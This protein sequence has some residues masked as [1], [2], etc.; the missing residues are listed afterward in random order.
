MTTP[1]V[2][3]GKTNLEVKL[4]SPAT[5]TVSVPSSSSI[6][7]LVPGAQGPK[8]DKGTKWYSGAGVPASGL[9][10]VDD[11][12]LNETNG[13]VYRKST[14]TTWVLE[15]NLTGPRGIEG[16]KWL[17]GAGV[18]ASGLGVITDFYLNSTNADYYEKTTATV[19]T[20]RGNIKGATGTMSLGTV[21][22]G[23]AGSSVAITN[24]GTP[25]AGIF[26][27]T[28]PRGDKGAT[29]TLALGTVTTSAAG[30]AAAITNTG[31]PE[32]GVFNFTIPRGDKGATGTMSVGTT[33]TGAPGTNA[34]VTNTGTPEA[35]IFNFTIPRGDKGNTG[36][37]SVG[38]V[39][40]GA[41]G[42]SAT[43][44]NTG[45]PEAGVFNFTIPRGDKGATG[46]LALGTVTTG[47]AG[48]NVSITN[49]GTPEAGVFNFTIPRG[50]KGERGTVWNY[51]TAAPATG[52]GLV[53]DWALNTNNGDVYEKTGAAVWTLRGNIKGA[54][55]T[56]SLG[57]V[58]TGAAGSAAS[59]TNTGTATAGVFN[60]VIPKGDTGERGPVGPAGSTVEATFTPNTAA[61]VP[62]TAKGLAGQTGDLQQWQNSAGT[63]VAEVNADGTFQ[64]DVITPV[65]KT[66]HWYV[67]SNSANEALRGHYQAE[68]NPRWSI[69]S[70]N[71]A[72]GNSGLTLNAPGATAAA[73]G[74]KFGNIGAGIFVLST[75]NG[76]AQ[77]ERMRV[78]AN[79]DTSFQGV[80]YSNQN[81]T[82]M[83]TAAATA[84]V[85][86][87][88]RTLQFASAYWTG[89]A[90]A[91]ETFNI[92]D[93]RQGAAPGTA[94]GHRLVIGTSANPD[95]NLFSI[96]GDGSSNVGIG[97]SFT[98][99]AAQLRISTTAPGKVATV[100]RGAASQT[101]NLLEFR[102]NADALLASV[103]FAGRFAAA[104]GT[105]AL[106]GFRFQSDLDTGL[107]R[108]AADQIGFATTGVNRLTLSGTALTST[109]AFT[110]T[111]L[112]TS[113]FASVGTTAVGG[114]SQLYAVSTAANFVTLGLR[115]A[116]SQ[117]ADL[118]QWQNSAGTVL[119]RIASD[120]SLNVNGASIANN[121]LAVYS[122][123][124]AGIPAIV[125]G[126]ASQTGDLQQ[127][128]NSAGTMLAEVMANGSF[129]TVGNV[130]A[131]GN[132]S[133]FGAGSASPSMTLQGVSGTSTLN[134][135]SNAGSAGD[136]IVNVSASGTAGLS[137]LRFANATTQISTSTN[138]GG[139]MDYAGTSHAF[140]SSITVNGT[141][142]T[143][144][145]Q[146]N[147]QARSSFEI[148]SGSSVNS[149]AVL[150][151]MTSYAW[152]PTITPFVGRAAASQTA[153]LLN[154]QN[155][156]GT[157]LAR[158]DSG[159]NFTANQLNTTGLTTSYI[160]TPTTNQFGLPLQVTATAAAGRGLV[161][162]G[163]NASQ[164]GDLQQWQNSAGAILA[165]VYAS[166]SMNFT[167]SI[168]GNG[169][170]VVET[171]DTFL[172]INQ[173]SQFSNGIWTGSSPIKTG[174]NGHI[175]VG[176]SGG[177]GN[178]ALLATSNGDAV[179]RITLDGTNGIA[180]FTGV[181]RAQGRLRAGFNG[182]VSSITP[183]TTSAAEFEL[184]AQSLITVGEAGAGSAN[185]AITLYRTYGGYRQGTGMRL[186]HK[187]SGG[188][189]AVQYGG[190][191]NNSTDSPSY[192]TETYA[193]LLVVNPTTG[194][195]T[196]GLLSEQ[197]NRVFSLGNK[198]P[199]AGISATGT[200][201][202]TTFLRGDGTWSVPVGGVTSVNTRTGAVTGLA[203]ANAVVDL[204]TNQSIAGQK[205]FSAITT[206]SQGFTTGV[207]NISSG[208]HTVSGAGV[209]SALYAAAALTLRPDASLSG[210]S[211]NT[212]IN[213]EGTYWNGTASATT[214]G[215][216]TYTSD[217]T[218]PYFNFTRDIYEKGSRVFSP[219]NLVPIS[220]ISATGTASSTTYLRGDGTWATVVGGVT[221]VNSRTG[222]V[223]GLAEAAN[224][225]D[226]TNTQSISGY[227]AFN[228]AL[229]VSGPAGST[230]LAVKGA[231][232]Q[233]AALAEWSD[234]G[235][236]SLVRVENDGSFSVF[237]TKV[238]RTSL[239]TINA[240]EKA[241]VVRGFASQSANLQEWWGVSASQVWGSV[242]GDGGL[243]MR[244]GAFGTISGVTGPGAAVVPLF[245]RGAASQTA[246]LTEWQNSAGTVMTQLRPTGAIYS[247]NSDAYAG[248]HTIQTVPTSRGLAIRGAAG[249]TMNLAEFQDS[250]GTV[251]TYLSANGTIVPQSPMSTGSVGLRIG[252][253]IGAS[254]NAGT[255][256]F[257]DGSGWKLNF[258]RANDGVTVASI[259]DRGNIVS[260][261]TNDLANLMIMTAGI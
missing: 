54:T 150:G 180:T 216:I 217:A 52:L 74:V 146:V 203:E 140:N 230:T 247:T 184:T 19:W 195:N 163:F 48:S 209:S 179:R 108:P 132:D 207:A 119:S 87:N 218:N 60:F 204:T 237:S 117:T 63:I 170:V 70:D 243:T 86:A 147:S 81:L 76:T 215:A 258:A 16:S 193:D 251:L 43:I 50:D 224:V 133:R 7:V 80:V 62:L 105:V 116:A 24:T 167:G 10:L 103:G 186:T 65:I 96:A 46:T 28:I 138:G 178:V 115:G 90:S 67:L 259:D 13:D 169:K 78:S 200:P 123:A 109:V 253:G 38:T 148:V 21:T 257:G 145:L 166:G 82:M 102:S 107:Y 223:T 37:M 114:V 42:S 59:I 182:L 93:A 85:Q 22:T 197:G 211:R 124:A 157:A 32:A 34:T 97:E 227:K 99:S 162:Q 4:V 39:T 101:A 134:V 254:P 72:S 136:A 31:T 5:A 241:L 1:I 249:Q 57:T 125:R 183:L 61:G 106:P 208:S 113:G 187:A 29:G 91:V 164:A 181:T 245:V 248:I 120:G 151:S 14:A 261:T 235:S 192:G 141:T 256:G 95:A 153:D 246:N 6:E 27:F 165:A 128:Q 23:A 35:G 185:P 79:G 111:S 45:T 242:S 112:A 199:M 191:A 232:S 190:T 205:T 11:F 154:L 233:T 25:T 2:L 175:Y 55:G 53:G 56:L 3:E 129:F 30:S 152:G 84:T 44:T 221:S 130:V 89:T 98:Q 40:T 36:T 214:T 202:A 252:G 118:T 9:G 71:Y 126:A 260:T 149:G 49:T 18:P 104:D 88:S 236:N 20:L 210:Q 244:R 26:N 100:I 231:A 176:G 92:M 177:D 240:T 73:G 228:G 239:G 159:G 143:S 189:F 68:V 219:N 75:S 161:V 156:A 64:S 144:N 206:F 168:A 110:A 137:A 135:F 160:G 173:S 174:P 198:V 225:V 226:L 194:T 33:T 234:S 212:N 131:N 155:S 127:W 188:D 12:Y 121:S 66:N 222:A 238:A 172:R 229:Y 41:A 213:M 255:I 51:V 139:R 17:T 94:G 250:A 47:A 77:V 158:V 196:L 171:G 8:G 83:N 122:M 58:T 15:D 69:G 142:T 220:G 201:S